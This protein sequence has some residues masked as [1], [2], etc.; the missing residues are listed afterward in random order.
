MKRLVC[1]SAAILLMLSAT[2]MFAADVTGSW[3]GSV[4]T[5]NGDFKLTFAFKQDGAKLTG[6]VTG[7]QG[8]PLDIANGKVDGNNISF[9]VS[10]NGMTIK[11]NGTVNGDEIKLT[12]KTDDP[13]FPGLELTLARAK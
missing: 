6:T 8:A 13:N 5:P 4:S 1:V 11:H 10:F 2:A 3:T 12:T 7:P 9:D